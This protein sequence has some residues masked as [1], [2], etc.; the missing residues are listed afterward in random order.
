MI[1]TSAVLY[2]VPRRI[3]HQYALWS[4]SLL[5]LTKVRFISPFSFFMGVFLIYAVI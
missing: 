4:A 5:T 3:H 2:L 1:A